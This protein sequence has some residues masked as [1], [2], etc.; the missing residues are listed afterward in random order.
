M[1]GVCEIAFGVLLIAWLWDLGP[2]S[3]TSTSKILLVGACLAVAFVAQ[4]ARLFIHEFG[5]LCAAKVV[6]LIPQKIQIGTGLRF[7]SA[8]RPSGLLWEWR[9]LPTAGIVLARRERARFLRM[10]HTVFILGGP[11]ADFSVLGAAYQVITRHFGGLSDA[12]FHGRIMCLTGALLGYM[13]VSAIANLIPQRIWIGGRK[14]WSDGYWLLRLLTASGSGI[15]QFEI[16]PL[17]TEA[18]RE[19]RTEREAKAEKSAF[20][21]EPTQAE[22]GRAA[23]EKARVRLASPLRPKKP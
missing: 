19:L 22:D 6:G 1:Q 2:V 9:L 4:H 3:E 5:H 8:V 14:Y 11:L 20:K 12:L 7:F 13:A 21:S 10:R 18:L 16:D 23:F 17:S 15:A